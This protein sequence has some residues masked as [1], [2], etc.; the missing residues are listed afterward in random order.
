M[1]NFPCSSYCV[2]SL[3]WLAQDWYPRFWLLWAGCCEHSWLCCLVDISNHFCWVCA[4]EGF[5]GCIFGCCRY[6][7]SKY[8]FP[9]CLLLYTVVIRGVFYCDFICISLMANHV[10][11]WSFVHLDA[12]CEI[13]VHNSFFKNCPFFLS[14]PCWLIEVLDV[15]WMVVLCQIMYGKYI[16]S[17]SLWLA[18]E[19][20]WGYLLKFHLS[21]F[22]FMLCFCVLFKN[23]AYL[24]IRKLFFQKLYWCTFHLRY[25]VCLDLIFVYDVR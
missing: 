12:L 15:F 22:S 14:F 23:K 6:C 10:L 1:L 5:S 3:S 25:A 8:S 20:S 18:F 16:Y 4:Q 9:K 24:K 21:C 2:F 7:Q 13:S 17:P 11:Y 19:L